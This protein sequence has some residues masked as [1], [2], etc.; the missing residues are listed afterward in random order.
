VAGIVLVVIGAITHSLMDPRIREKINDQELTAQ[1]LLDAFE[2]GSASKILWAIGLM[3][4]VSGAGL[5]VFSPSGRRVAMRLAPLNENSF[6]QIMAFSLTI[7]LLGA[8]F[9]PLIILHKPPPLAVDTL[10]DNQGVKEIVQTGLLQRLLYYRLIWAIPTALM[11]AGFPITRSFFDALDRLGIGRLSLKQIGAAFLV[12]VGLFCAQFALSYLVNWL[13]GLFGW[14]TTDETK[15]DDLFK[16]F[17]NYSGAIA[18][19]LVAGISEELAFRGL[20][21]P[22]LGL[23]LSNTLFAAVHAWQYHWDGVVI[24]FMIGL[25]CG[26][27]RKYVNTTAAILVHGSYDTLAVLLMMMQQQS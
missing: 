1:Q 23:V 27:V 11:A 3:L 6:T 18:I 7:V 20:L 8:C 9:L 19:G 21:Q 26:L 12:A 24:V 16:A 15:F 5:F 14:P 4:L 13:W 22:R 25:I 17:K 10:A 2:P